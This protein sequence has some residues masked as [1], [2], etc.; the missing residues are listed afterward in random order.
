MNRA[1]LS[2]LYLDSWQEVFNTFT[3]ANIGNASAET[4]KKIERV[5]LLLFI[6]DEN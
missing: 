4:V 6:K 3:D 1:S 2:S 5:E